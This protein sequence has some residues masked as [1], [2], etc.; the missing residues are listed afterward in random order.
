ME[1][2]AALVGMAV[3]RAAAAVRHQTVLTVAGERHPVSPVSGGFVALRT[4][5]FEQDLTASLG[6]LGWGRPVAFV[7]DQWGLARFAAAATDSDL[8]EAPPTSGP[9][10]VSFVVPDAFLSRR[11]AAIQRRL[12]RCR[13]RPRGAVQTVHAVG[14]GPWTVT[15]T[16]DVVRALEGVEDV[17]MSDWTYA[18]TLPLL[19]NHDRLTAHVLPYEFG[20]FDANIHHVDDAL[21]DLHE[22][23]VHHVGLLIEGNPDTYDVL[24]GLPLTNR[25]IQVTPGV[26]IGLLAASRNAARFR[27][28][29]FE[30]SFA[31]FSGLHSRHKLPAE[32]FLGEL[33]CYLAAGI[34]CV[35][36]EMYKGDVELALRAMRLSG[37]PA[38]ALLMSD[39]FSGSE[40]TLVLNQP[41]VEA[42]RSAVEATRGGLCTMLITDE[43]LR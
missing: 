10:E 24:D 3:F 26:P 31:Y 34:T 23:G 27:T 18:N 25:E 29:P 41:D 20:D 7:G 22:K 38:T 35:L 42:A 8:L 33:T 19:P 37:R 17:V 43:D 13:P 1:N 4:R 21:R 39:Y 36:V 14:V 9:T 5:G 11:E 2:E 28:D 6:V 12:Q 32:Q 40:N 15:D 16:G 30:R